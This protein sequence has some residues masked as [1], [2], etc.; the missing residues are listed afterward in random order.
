MNVKRKWGNDRLT[1]NKQH[2]LTRRQNRVDQNL[3]AEKSLLTN[4]SKACTFKT[5][6]AHS[7]A[8]F[9]AMANKRRPIKLFVLESFDMAPRAATKVHQKYSTEQTS[10]AGYA[11]WPN[12]F[13]PDGN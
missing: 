3:A 2:L 8:V 6:G 13:L 11:V 10:T 1:K 12:H 9:S 5:G 4:A 7:D